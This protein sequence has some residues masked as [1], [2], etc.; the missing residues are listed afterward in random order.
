M[1]PSQP[2]LDHD[3]IE[4][5]DVRSPLLGSGGSGGNRREGNEQERKECLQMTLDCR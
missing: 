3:S 4:F 1:K 2:S 5:D